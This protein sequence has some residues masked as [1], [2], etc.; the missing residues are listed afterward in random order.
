MSIAL[1]RGVYRTSFYYRKAPSYQGVL[2]FYR[3]FIF[4]CS[5]VDFITMSCCEFWFHFC[6][7]IIECHVYFSGDSG[8]QKIIKAQEPTALAD[9]NQLQKKYSRQ[10]VRANVEGY[11][12][13]RFF[14]YV[15]Q[16]PDK[17]L[18]EK[19][20]SAIKVYRVFLVGVKD[21]FSDMKMYLKIS[22]IVNSSAKGLRALTRKELELYNQIPKDMLKV[23]PVLL[24]SALPF[25][26]YVIF[27]LA[28]VELKII[29]CDDL[30]I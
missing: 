8:S 11:F 3:W 9:K 12:F 10:N 23:A 28:W 18:Q 13:P 29:H 5:N 27:P 16:Y 26:S 4:S 25:A 22:R 24:S 15:S 30:D 1:I 7:W 14:Q 17:I 21:F 19:F 2:K 6:S 20:P